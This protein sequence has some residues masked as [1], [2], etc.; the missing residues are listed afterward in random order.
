[1]CGICGYISKN[2]ITLEQL[3]EMNDTMYHRGPDDSGEEIYEMSGGRQVGFAQRRLSILDLS[4]LGH[5]PMHSVDKRVS[6]VYNG[7]IYNYRELKEELADYPFLSNCDTEVIIAAYLKWGIRCVERFNGMFAIALYDRETQDVYLVRDRIGKKPLYYRYEDENLVFASELKPIMKCP[8]FA[9]EIEQRVLSRYLFQQYINAP[10]SIYRN[11]YK[12]EPGSVLRFSGGNIKTWKYWDVKKVYHRAQKDRIEDY[13]EAKER[14]KDLLQKSVKARMIAD[15]PLGAFLS[16]GYDS[17][18]VTA[19]A[20]ECS[21]DPVKTF[22]IGFH[23][24]KYNEAKYAKA[25]ADYLGTDHTEL[26]IGE[27]DMLGLVE[28]IPKYYDEPFA[29]SS[30][31]ATMMVSKLARDH[32]TVALSGDGGDEFFCGYNVYDNVSK[33]QRL[34]KLGGMVHGLCGLPGFKQAHLEDRLPF[35]VRVIAGNRER[36]SKTQFGAGNYP[37]VA[38]AMVK[39]LPEGEEAFPIH[40]PVE[41]G[42]GVG[43]WQIRRMLLDMDTYLPGDILCKVDRA[44]MKYS[45]EARC[46]ILDVD[47][48]ELSYRIPHEFKYAGGD[49]K[50][51]L[52]DIAYDYIPKD[53]L[54]RPK[55]GFGV[56]LDK[57]LRGP[58]R[59][60]LLDY[61]SY[62]FLER[63]NIFDATYV[64]DMIGQYIET[65]DAGPATGANYS[66]LV[67]S[68]FVFQQWYQTYRN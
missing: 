37:V 55:V 24:E 63:Q 34:D 48:M 18:L 62:D 44:S 33:A 4:E 38:R 3:K 65:G 56:P 23:E 27:Q 15:V 60:Q 42:Y 61:S 6:V 22:S 2:S 40:Y 7:E 64:S 57:W 67:W 9:G 1:M 11:V 47:V 14:L 5:Q 31:I 32:V 43:N 41:S 30:E 10:E 19:I 50:H 59:E 46:P 45:L 29:D 8:G 25:V 13:R 28:S 26:Y 20:Q 66:K 17:S 39:A 36:E 58:L 16:G 49:K 21:E 51:I 52:K 53:L 54:D 68:F 12:V 35:K